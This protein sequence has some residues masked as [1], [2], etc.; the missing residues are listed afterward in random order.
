MFCGLGGLCGIDVVLLLVCGM[1]FE[2]Y[3]G[4]KLLR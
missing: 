3:N 1:C 2:W 4:C